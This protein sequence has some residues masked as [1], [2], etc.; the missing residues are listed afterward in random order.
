MLFLSAFVNA[1][2]DPLM[3]EQ[4]SFAFLAVCFV[5]DNKI[6]E[7]LLESFTACLN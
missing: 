6:S 1:R 3:L 2:R 5:A 4:T 7:D